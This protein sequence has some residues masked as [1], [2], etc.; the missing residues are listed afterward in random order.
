MQS[1]EW[2]SGTDSD[3]DMKMSD[4]EDTDSMFSDVPEPMKAPTRS[5]SE[6]LV[7]DSFPRLL[8]NDLPMDNI[9]GGDDI[10]Q[11]D[12]PKERQVIVDI[13]KDN[14]PEATSSYKPAVTRKVLKRKSAEN[15]EDDKENRERG[16]S[17]SEIIDLENETAP[18]RTNQG[19]NID[20]DPQ[21]IMSQEDCLH[22][23]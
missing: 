18:Y 3:Y 14:N 16:H 22:S 21:A 7:P 13:T 1:D 10:E 23:F 20:I 6:E 2:S 9:A 15:M 17:I 12:G 5:A 19:K 11:D 4:D 8:E